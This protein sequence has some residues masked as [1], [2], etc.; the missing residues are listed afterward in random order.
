MFCARFPLTITREGST[1]GVSSGRQFQNVDENHQEIIYNGNRTAFYLRQA[2]DY[3]PKASLSDYS[4][5]LLWRS[6][7]FS[8]VLYLVRTKNIKQV[9]DTFFQGFTTADQYVPSESEWPWHLGGASYH[10]RR[11][12]IVSQQRRYLISIFNMGILYF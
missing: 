1:S 6:K 12:S 8:T 5:E 4:E 3:S 7:A 2:K 9:R 10:Q 11:T